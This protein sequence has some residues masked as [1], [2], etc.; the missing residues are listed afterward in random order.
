MK[1]LCV[2]DSLGS[3][4]AQRQMV[5][6]AIGLKARGHSVYVFIYYPQHDFFESRLVS[7]GVDLIKFDKSKRYSLGVI[8]KLLMV[9]K[10]GDYDIV[11]SFLKTPNIYAELGR[12][13]G[14]CSTLI[15]SERS[16]HKAIG[17]KVK[18]SIQRHMHSFSDYIVV[19]SHDQKAWLA[20]EYSALSKK[21]V[22][23]YNGVEKAKFPY[24]P[25]V[26]YED[27]KDATLLSVGR[28]GREKNPEVLIRALD[29]FY[30]KLGWVP[31]VLWVGGQDDSVGGRQYRSEL[32]GILLALPHVDKKWTWLGVRSNV[33]EYLQRSVCLVLP[34][35]YEG[36]PNAVCEALMS[37]RPV[38]A[39]NVCDNGRLVEDGARGY[40][41][42]SENP[43]SLCLAIEKLLNLSYEER[44]SLGK[45]A[46]KYAEDE[47][48]VELMVSNYEQLFG[49]LIGKQVIMEPPDES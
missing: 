36:L 15:V 45:N 5:E 8:R 39:S 26:R 31:E 21:I 42:E 35:L 47:L 43:V 4:G 49:K 17:S 34:S 7:G 48:G 3:G 28:I 1:I 19:N 20:R 38:I 24:T 13:F 18:G 9:L 40:L 41:F 23:I 44:A 32:Q 6:L 30:Q 25:Q 22:C 37:G 29:V 27:P 14:Y 46:R 11:L 16:S 12:L 2:I 10:E 33:S